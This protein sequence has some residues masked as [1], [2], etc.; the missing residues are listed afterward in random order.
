M[1]NVRTPQKGI[2]LTHTVDYA[3]RFSVHVKLYYRIV[4]HNA[5]INDGER[6]YDDLC[7]P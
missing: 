2:F 5:V 1:K 3:L 4:S 7:L 6:I